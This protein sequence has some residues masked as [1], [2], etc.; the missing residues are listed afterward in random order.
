MRVLI[1]T[2]LII[3]GM[4]IFSGIADQSLEMVRVAGKT[5]DIA[6]SRQLQL[7]LELYYADNGEYPSIESGEQLLDLLLSEGYVENKL[8]DP[9]IFKYIQVE[10]GQDFDLALR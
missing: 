5:A 3:V 10:N 1:L 9:S 7:A 2:A 6:S 8:Q 4:V